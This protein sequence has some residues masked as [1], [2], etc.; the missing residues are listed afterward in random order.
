[1]VNKGLQV[2]EPAPSNVLCL[3]VAEP[4][5]SNVLCLQVAEPPPSNVFV[6]YISRELQQ[7]CRIDIVRDRYLDSNIIAHTR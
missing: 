7:S 4:A 2:A 5:P 6:P 3:Q 1:M